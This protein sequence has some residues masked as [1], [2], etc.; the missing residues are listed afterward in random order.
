MNKLNFIHVGQQGTFKK[1]G[2][3]NSTPEDIDNLISN[4]NEKDSNRLA[5]YFHGGLVNEKSGVKSGTAMNKVF[6]DA[7]SYPISFVWDTGL[8]ETLRERIP[9]IHKTRFFRK[10][11]FYVIKRAGSKIGVEIGARGGVHKLTEEEIE[12]EL[13]KKNPFENIVV[14]EGKRSVALSFM[15]DEEAFINKLEAEIEE[16][17]ESDSEFKQLA[18]NITV[19][20]HID[21]VHLRQL[22]QTDESGVNKRGL[23]SLVGLIK[24]IALITFRVIR[25]HFKKR[26]HGF[27][28]TIVEEILREYYIA[29]VGAWVWQGMK[30]KAYEMWQSNS[31][32]SG[33]DMHVGTYF[34]DALN[35][36]AKNKSF[37][38]DLVGHSAGSIVI[39]HLLNSI[40][41][42]YPNL[43]IRKI[44]LLAPACRCE[45]FHQEVLTKPSRFESVRIF[46]MSDSYEKND[47]L[48]DDLPKFYPRSLLYFISGVLENKGKDYDAYILGLERHISWN[49]YLNKEPILKNINSFLYESLPERLVYSKTDDNAVAGYRSKAIDHGAFDDDEETQKSILN[50]IK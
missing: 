11:L 26:T 33:E 8:G 44:A 49:S 1:S 32:R 35:E 46:T 30:D 43:K 18:K 15:A 50:L 13:E 21:E 12:V 9:K 40:E 7:K 45:L 23:F 4:L 2:I 20:N 41:S 24:G 6:K 36:L 14:N 38:I 19:E 37:T 42:N 39:C 16:D 48:V 47:A 5:L 22:Q 10:L 17:I 25:R 31:T 29:N 27:Y 34:L 28:P 3:F